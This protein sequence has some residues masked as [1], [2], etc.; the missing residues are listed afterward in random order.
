MEWGV[1]WMPTLAVLGSPIKHS[2]SP[3]I[4]LAAYRHLG[5]DWTYQACEVR[6]GELADFLAGLDASWLGLSLTMPLKH[7]ILPLLSETSDLAATLGV[8]NTVLFGWGPHAASPRLRGYNTDVAGLVRPARDRLDDSQ[9]VDRVAILGAGATAASALAAAHELGATQATVYARSPLKAKELSPLAQVLGLALQIEDIG[10]FLA[11]TSRQID[12]DL[13]FCVL[14][15]NAAESLTLTPHRHDQLLFDISYHPWPPTLST[16]WSSAGGSVL[17]GL[18]M[19]V[20]QA[21]EQIRIFTTHSTSEPLPDEKTLTGL[22]MDAA[23]ASL[24]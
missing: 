5:L 19:L 15:G 2:L 1:V 3:V 23:V 24:N 22:M 16:R 20:A 18:D 7:E 4:H 8:A 9:P 21:L 10:Q 6:S 17:T 14:P 11:G 12:A 13:L